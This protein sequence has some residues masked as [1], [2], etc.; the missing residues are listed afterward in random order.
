M[1]AKSARLTEAARAY[2]KKKQIDAITVDP[3]AMGCCGVADVMSA[4]T[5]SKGEP[6]K[7]VV[8]YKKCDDG[9]V[10]IYYPYYANVEGS[11]LMIDVET[12]LGISR[13]FVA[14]GKMEY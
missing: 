4:S 3:P 10:A 13:L 7:D 5:V 6:K 12:F 11:C 9:G 2:V 8:V 1:Y 14:N